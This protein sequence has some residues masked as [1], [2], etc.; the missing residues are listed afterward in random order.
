MS[1]PVETY[2]FGCW[3]ESGHYLWTPNMA[4]PQGC[5][6]GYPEKLNGRYLDCGFCPGI[7]VY[8]DGRISDS[9]NV[10][11]GQAAV[12]HVDDWTVLSFWDKSVDH[13]PG[14]H[15]T[16][17]IRGTHAFENAVIIARERFPHVWARYK[18]DVVAYIAPSGDRDDPGAA[19]RT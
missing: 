15:S 19:R 8:K 12:V 7:I 5:P 17:L 4:R 13:R 6:F 9:K 10:P 2:Y 11:D 1:E 3:R 18:F 14:S 16:Y